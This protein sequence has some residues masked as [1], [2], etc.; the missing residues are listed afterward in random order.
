[1]SVRATSICEHGTSRWDC[2]STVI[3][4][5]RRVPNNHGKTLEPTLPTLPTLPN[6]D[7]FVFQFLMLSLIVACY[8]SKKELT[9]IKWPSLTAKNGKK[10]R[11]QRKMFCRIGSYKTLFS[12]A[13]Q[14]L[15]LSLCVCLEK[16]IDHK[17]T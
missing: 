10:F 16:F 9:T 7:F 14:F 5:G 6:F 8:I 1:L 13:L 15:L 4:L 2:S 11:Q 12:I 3:L 17:M